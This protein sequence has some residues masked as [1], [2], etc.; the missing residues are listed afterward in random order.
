MFANLSYLWPTLSDPLGLGWNLFGTLNVNWQP[1]LTSLVPLLQTSVLVVGLA[2][3]CVTARNI[4]AEKSTGRKALLQASPVMGFCFAV[5]A[6][7]M[8]LLIG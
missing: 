5:T 4:A 8:G 2:W 3:A 1:Y 7:L 6:S